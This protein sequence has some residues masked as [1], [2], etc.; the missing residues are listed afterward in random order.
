M[1]LIQRLWRQNRG[2]LFFLLLMSLFRSAIADWNVVPSGS[3]L[4]TIQIGDRILVDKLAYDIRIPFTHIQLWHLHDPQRGDIV[5]IDSRAAHEL[6]VKRLI[7]VPG[8]L[9]SMRANVL[10]INGV[11]AH[12]TGVS[13]SPQAGDRLSPAEY[14]RE[15]V[16]GSSRIVRL[17]ELSPSPR[18]SFGPWRVPDGQ[19]LM[20][21]DNRDD[22]AD[23]RY[24][25]FFKRSELMGRARYVAYSLDSGNYYLPRLN[26]LGAALDH[27]AH[28]PRRD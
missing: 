13:E 7:A 14:L 5:T 22:S 23:S 3:M 21:G 18:D 1:R 17:S 28:Q 9:V 27:A 20:L 8:D 4:P 12:Y 16:D 6:L 2:V 11:E 10:I 19:Y 24:F 15:H 26:R 25:G